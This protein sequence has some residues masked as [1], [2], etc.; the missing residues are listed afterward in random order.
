MEKNSA[1]IEKG[2]ISVIIPIFKVEKFIEKT[3]ES[4]LASSYKKLEIICVDDGS[5]DKSL[6]IVEK[7]RELDDRIKIVKNPKNFG[8]FRARVEGMKVATGEYVAFVDSDDQI[9]VDWFRLLYNKITAEKADM[10]I[11]NTVNV[12]ENGNYT[13]YNNYRSFTSSHQSIMQPDVLDAFYSQE[14]ANYVWHTVWNKLYSRELIEKGLHYFKK[15]DFRLI[16]CEDVAFSSVFYM[17]AKKLSFA[18]ADAYFYWHHKSASTS[19]EIPKSKIIENINDVRNVFKFV[20]ESIVEYDKTLFEKYEKN[21]LNFKARYHRIWSNMIISKDMT[22]DKDI[23]KAMQTAFDTKEMIPCPPKDFYFTELTTPWSNRYEWVKKQ[24]ISEDVKVVSFD[25]FDTLV[26]RP[27]YKPEDIFFYLGLYVKKLLPYLNEKTF[28][29]YRF[30]AENR[31]RKKISLDNPTWEDVSLVEIY[32]EFAK[33]LVVD[34]EI[35]NKIYQEEK[36]LEVYFCKVRN[37]VKDLFDLAI[38]SGK[39]VIVTS[40]MYLEIDTVR[41]I[42]NNNGYQKVDR[43]FLSS[44][45]RSLKATGTLFNVMLSELNVKPEEVV[46]LGDNWNSDYIIP[47]QKGI[48]TLFVPK[49]KEAFENIIGDI[50]TGNDLSFYKN[51]KSDIVDMGGFTH[52]SALSSMLGL[53]MNRLFDNPFN[54]YQKESNYNG[55]SYH[56]GYYTLGMHVFGVADWMYKTAIEKGIK[57]VVFL[58]RDG[59]VVKQAFDLICQASSIKIESDYFYASRASLMPYAIRKPEDLFGL[60][61]FI[62][63]AAGVHSPESI[64]AM[65]SSVLNPLTDEIRAKYKASGVNLKK[66]IVTREAFNY[67]AKMVIRFSYNQALMDYKLREIEP[68]FADIFPENCATFD[69]GYSGRLQS[70]I[71]ALAG[72]SVDAF[73]IHTNG[74]VSETVAKDKFNIYSFYDFAPVMSSVV[75]E[76]FISKSEPSCVGYQVVDGKLSFAFE[77]RSFAYESNYAIDKFQ[78][79]AVDFCKD[80]LQIYADYLPYLNF[81]RV[82]V[83]APFDHFMLYA[84]SFDRYVYSSV[85]IEDYVYSGYKELSFFTIW[86]N[87]VEGKLPKTVNQVTEVTNFSEPVDLTTGMINYIKPWSK[88]KRGLFFLLFDRKMFRKKLKKNLKR[89]KDE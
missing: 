40:D 81:R 72:K 16:M 31:A 61:E 71:C 3:L 77:E 32:D 42:L 26:V 53:C 1:K 49:T 25:M 46:H 38:E 37:A 28:Y 5:P 84:S 51:Y 19:C 15:I 66:K 55:D 67:F 64:L 8:L 85:M 4:V 44:E 34:K 73:F 2:L 45:M 48:K 10:V 87:I 79:G 83:S 78:Q 59:Y 57:K 17:L 63:I 21:Y 9:G 74:N 7:F 68:I 36:R 6:L 65:L 89:Q 70:I 18:N 13:Y 62:N 24:I 58:A 56:T 86:S 52:D 22:K 69:V 41:E 33:L 47:T 20:K 35:V 29:D 60:Y 43:I 27:F 50:Y 76:F 82:E 12:D 39:K 54:P 23:V 88:F 80:Y 75:R 11:G 30:V 14:G